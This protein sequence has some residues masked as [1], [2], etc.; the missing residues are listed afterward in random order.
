MDTRSAIFIPCVYSSS[1]S[2]MSQMSLSM[3]PNTSFLI[4]NFRRV[5]NVHAFFWVIPRPLNFIC[6]RFE[7]LSVPSSD[8][9]AHEDGTECSETS[10]FKIQAP[11]NYPEER[12]QNKVSYS[13]TLLS[14]SLDPPF[15]F[16]K[17]LYYQ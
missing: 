11:G 5:L 8:L 1:F 9:P 13:F 17:Y 6:R 2:W 16:C 3:I 12:K 10:A 7:T 15:P 14:S 4:S